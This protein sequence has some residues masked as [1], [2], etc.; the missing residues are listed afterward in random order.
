MKDQKKKS[1][2]LFLLILLICIGIG[3]ALL[4]QEI[5]INGVSTVKN[6]SWDIHFENLSIN[7]SSVPL[8]EGDSAAEID[9]E[10]HTRVYCV[11]TLKKPGDYYSFTVDAVNAGTIDGMIE[12][13]SFKMNDSVITTLPP[14]LEYS[15]TYD[16]GEEIIS[17][18]IL[19]AGDQETFIVTV[20]F[21]KDI[22]NS[23]LPTSPTTIT[24]SFEAN[25][26]QADESAINRYNTYYMN[27]ESRA[28]STIDSSWKYY[29]K[30]KGK[31]EQYTEDLY[32]LKYYDND[33]L[34]STDTNNFHY[35]TLND[36]QYLEYEDD[37]IV[38]GVIHRAVCE[39]IISVGD[40]YYSHINAKEACAIAGTTTI[41]LKPG[42]WDCDY[43]EGTCS[44][45]NGYIM[46][47]KNIME[48]AGLNCTFEM[49]EGGGLAKASHIENSFL[50]CS[51]NKIGLKAYNDGKVESYEKEKSTCQIYFE[52]FSN[53][54]EQSCGLDD[55][56]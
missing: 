43:N 7:D 53:H 51:N 30:G 15:V 47:M 55:G 32:V 18:Q 46:T 21:K 33:E 2:I 9:S 28:Q 5:K 39:K 19:E 49:G 54:Y 52:N 35:F 24:L 48:N 34:I 3:Y 44:N 22:T 37:D 20:T 31:Q 11:V 14:Y 56:R 1:F 16:D 42:K 38:E 17:N 23:D 25:Y 45:T 4:T 8:S 50:H 41:C 26:V 27:Y 36:C 12:S 29:I 6:S 40:I 13:T 10:T